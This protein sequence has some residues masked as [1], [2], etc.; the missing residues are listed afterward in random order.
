MRDRDRSRGPRRL[1]FGALVTIGGVAAVTATAVAQGFLLPAPPSLKGIAPPQ[2]DLSAYVEDEQ[3]LLVLGKSLFWDQ[4]MGSQGVACATCHFHAGADSRVKN[5]I[6]PGLLDGDT[7]FGDAAGKYASGAA[8]GPNYTLKRS[9]FPLFQLADEDDRDS[10]ITF[11]TNDVVSSQGAF[12]GQYS[13]TYL[14]T[15]NPNDRC[16][17]VL[18]PV[19]H[20]GGENVRRVEPRNTPTTV[21]AVYYVRQFWDGRANNFFNGVNPFGQRDINAKVMKYDDVDGWQPVPVAIPNLSL[22]SQAVG[23]VE[24]DLEMICQGRS[25]AEFGRKVLPRQPLSQQKVH[26]SDSVLGPH[27]SRLT[28]GRGIQGTYEEWV[29]KA[30]KPEWWTGGAIPAGQPGEGYTQMEA[31]FS[32]FWG[33]AVAQYQATLISDDAKYDRVRSGLPGASF[34]AQEQQGLDLFRSVNVGCIFCHGGP[35]FSNATFPASAG[36]V[37]RVPGGASGQHLIDAGFFN[38]GVR[39]TS[40][41]LGVGG[42]DPF[43]KPL[44]LARQWIAKN[45]DDPSDDSLIVDQFADDDACSFVTPFNTDAATGC[46]PPASAIND[47]ELGVDGA[48]KSPMLRN[49]E[50][51]GPYFHYGAYASLE[52]VMDFY[53]RGGDRRL[54][55]EPDDTRTDTS[56]TVGGNSSNLA[57]AL[58]PLGLSADQKASLVA[59]MKTLTDDRVRCEKAPFDHPALRIQHG[60]AGDQSEL[61][62]LN[63]DGKPD[64][65]YIDIP[66]VGADGLPGIRRPCIGTFESKLAIN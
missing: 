19:Y 3:A 29:R 44:S 66:A 40:E 28:L 32:L 46:M 65:Q 37:D 22:A 38:I 18:D 54:V 51:T 24:S 36:S 21:N 34:T 23:P 45:N 17:Q 4:G 58:V 30:F 64:E 27:F 13:G 25:L 10:P 31:N 47:V 12:L 60:M 50:L 15:R 43:G 16:D 14:S 57:G 20:V 63:G 56:G 62:D 7:E 8:A 55:N 42:T 1:L 39:P 11:E 5:Q 59:F 6:S 26:R 33:I 61:L 35:L 52:E 9:D 2:P 49:V 48:F 53:N 41:D